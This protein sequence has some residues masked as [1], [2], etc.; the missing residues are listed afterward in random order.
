MARNVSREGSRFGSSDM[1]TMQKDGGTGRPGDTQKRDGA[2][3]RHGDGATLASRTRRLGKQFLAPSPRRPVAQSSFSFAPS[4]FFAAFC[5]LLSAFCLLP[6]VFSQSGRPTP[7]PP[8]PQ[9]PSSAQGQRPVSAPADETRPRRTTDQPQDE[10]PLKLKADL[11]TVITSVTDSAGNQIN[12]LA[13]RDFEVYEDNALQD[14]AGFYREGQIPLRLIFLF[15]TSSSIR[16]RFEFEQ[17]AAALFFRNVMRPG[18]QAALMSVSTES[19]IELQFTPDV[20]QLITALGQLKPQGA[21]ALYDGMITAA[22]YLRP[23]EGRHVMV[24]LS[25]GTD[26]VSTST[27]AQALTEAQR[28]D[29]A[30]YAVHSTGV[31][32]SASVQDLAGEFVMKAMCE[33]TGGRAFFPPIYEDQKKETR[34]LD[35]IYKRLAA[36][37]RAQFVLTYYSKSEAKPGTFKPIRVEVK[38]PGVQVRAR[39]GYYTAK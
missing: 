30:I 37:V 12:D 38:R 23:S 29:M 15:D 3:R 8:K 5:L 32:P 17:R 1:K 10:K 13:Q 22:R 25:D 14:I 24:V 11:V 31:A 34:D 21:T 33:D 35:E 20:E 19:K 28:S 2:T 4:L 16:H 6:S 9:T 39:R 26:T 7:P 18:D 36:E 27:L